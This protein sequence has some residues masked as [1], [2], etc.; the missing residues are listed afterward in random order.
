MKNQAQTGNK[1]LEIKSTDS[2]GSVSEKSDKE[3]VKAAREKLGATLKDARLRSGMS[4]DAVAQITRITRNYIV[5][6]ESGQFEKLPGAVF[7]RG[8]VR[9][10]SR[11]LGLDQEELSNLYSDGWEAGKLQNT[12]RAP[13]A[14]GAIS[15][16]LSARRKL[17]F[18]IGNL[19][20]KRA[21]PEIKFDSQKQMALLIAAPVIAI[22]AAITVVAVRKGNAP[23]RARVANTAPADAT[24]PVQSV[25]APETPA[26]AAAE[27]EPAQPAPAAPATKPAVA[28][29]AAPAQQPAAEEPPMELRSEKAAFEQVLELVVI[30]PVKIKLVQDGKAPSVKQLKPDA[31]RF[32]FSDRAEL[33]VY[34]AAAMEVAFNGR[35]LGS[36]GAKGRIRKLIFQS[37]GPD[38]AASAQGQS[39]VGD[40]EKKL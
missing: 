36:L 22:F 11:L 29:A 33:T 32:S 21:L 17:K 31:Y 35:S 27:S 19:L 3:R 24:I 7:G 1:E 23:Q 16:R 9:S 18:D 30:E 4:E 10:I 15:Q 20:Q 8:F 26:V 38:S 28:A 5:A 12:L 2:D 39:P 37:G 14:E 40:S 13:A 25:T 34:D 6:L